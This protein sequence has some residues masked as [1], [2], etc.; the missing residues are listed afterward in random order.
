VTSRALL[1][2]AGICLFAAVLSAQTFLDT[3]EI[4]VRSG[5]YVP[6]LANALKVDATL[7]EASVVV[8]DGR[9]RAV[10]G[11]QRG[12]FEIRDE[13]KKREIRSFVVENSVHAGA[14][15]AVANQPAGAAPSPANAKIRTRWIGLL[16]DDMNS[17]A[18]DLI[19]A[20]I[21]AVRFLKEGLQPGDQVSIFTTFGR[22]LLPFT[23]DTAVITAALD[24]VSPHPRTPRPGMCPSVTPYEAY[25]IISRTDPSVL[26][27]KADEARRCSNTPA[28]RR[29]S[30]SD[31]VDDTSPDPAVQMAVEEARRIWQEVEQNS[32][33]TLGAFHDIVDYMGRLQGDRLLLA[34]SSGFLSGTLEM[35]QDELVDR[36]IHAGVVIDAL[37]AKGLFTETPIQSVP[38]MSVRSAIMQGSMGS[39]PQMAA[40]DALANLAY[41]TGGIF[42]HNNND[43]TAGIREMMA[44]EVTYLIGFAP[45]ESPDG[46]YHKLKVRVTAGKS[47]DVQARPGYMALA[48][49]EEERPAP[50]KIDAEVL[51][52][53]DRNDAPATFAVTVA[54]DKTAKTVSMVLHVDLKKL[55]LKELFGTRSQKLT[56]IA[57]LMDQQGNFV[58]GR[59]YDIDLALKE[60]TL[61]Q[62]LDGGLNLTAQLQAP[63]G[64]YRLRGVLEVGGDGKTTSATMPVEIH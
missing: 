31:A 4:T 14:S 15:A 36:A 43:L 12:N 37:D 21:A 17:A 58:T 8:R 40:N 5:V 51:A 39:R 13:G 27:V 25:L 54:G 63:K 16:F 62:Y 34:A 59:E 47:V 22:Q 45:D 11:L 46:K 55:T 41:S 64:T 50:R 1:T 19:S 35:E 6:R 48:A 33:N 2:C 10:P 32:R 44:P 49:K 29:R 26:P 9:G 7:V 3:K 56:Y 20:R 42:F 61:Q 38:G 52:P 57:A 24:K 18:G 30:R 53:D 60:S 28:P 23:T